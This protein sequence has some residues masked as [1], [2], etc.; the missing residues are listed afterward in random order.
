LAKRELHCFESL[1]CASCGYAQEA[2]GHE[3]DEFI[4][5]ALCAVHGRWSAHIRDL[6]PNRP[7]DLLALR[8]YLDVTPAAALC[9][10][11]EARP[12]A[13]GALVEIEQVQAILEPAGIELAVVRL[14]DCPVRA[15]LILRRPITNP[16]WAWTGRE[17]WAE[18]Q[19]VR[20]GDTRG[21]LDSSVGAICARWSSA[22]VAA[23][24]ACSSTSSAR[25]AARVRV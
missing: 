2:D 7:G 14:P 22:W 13:Q 12:V 9:I 1:R 10:V 6:G 4:R 21:A 5:S 25:N 19:V 18:G 24:E 17:A 8:S 20:L 16:A 15:D 3:I 23:T 11:R